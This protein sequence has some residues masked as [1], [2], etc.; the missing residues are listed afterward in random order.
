MTPIELNSAERAIVWAEKNRLETIPLP[1]DLA[2]EL[3]RAATEAQKP[4]PK[5]AELERELKNAAVRID[6]LQDE[7]NAIENSLED[8]QRELRGLKAGKVG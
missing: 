6:E 1:T 8:A 7:R 4:D 3:Y 5:I 2:R